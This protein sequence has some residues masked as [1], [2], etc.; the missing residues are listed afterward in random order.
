MSPLE[1]VTNERFQG[2]TYP[3]EFVLTLTASP[4]EILP[5]NPNRL[6]WMVLNED[7]LDGRVSIDPQITTTTGWILAANGGVIS[8]FWEEDGEAVGYPVY[9]VSVGAGSKVRIREVIRS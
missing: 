8:M 7:A 9:G 2:K 3:N 5:N 4:A 6:F 1:T